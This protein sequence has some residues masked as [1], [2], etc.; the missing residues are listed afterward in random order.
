[1][2]YQHGCPELRPYL[3]SLARWSSGC[4]AARARPPPC[5]AGR[6]RDRALAT[7]KINVP[8]HP[9]QIFESLLGFGLFRGRFLRFWLLSLVLGVFGVA[10]FVGE[11]K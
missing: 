11:V 1:M 4:A 5:V 8:S 2:G 3:P 10:Y 7:S 9:A 6:P